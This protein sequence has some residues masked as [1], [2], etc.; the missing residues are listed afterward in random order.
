MEP[1][2]EGEVTCFYGLTVPEPWAVA[3]LA[4]QI[5]NFAAE[6]AWGRALPPCP[7]HPHP[8]SPTVIGDVAVW[9]CPRDPSHYREPILRE[10]HTPVGW[11][12]RRP[13]E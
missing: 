9:H 5:Q 3:E 12:L 11:T 2:Y 4:S 13:P 8:L 6:A 10:M 1:E 7:G